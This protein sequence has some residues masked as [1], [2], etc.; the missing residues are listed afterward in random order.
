MASLQEN[1][2]IMAE[3]HPAVNTMKHMRRQSQDLNGSHAAG[4]D[5]S[6]RNDVVLFP[7]TLGAA[8]EALMGP[9]QVLRVAFSQGIC[10][11]WA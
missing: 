5:R 2:Q 10:N 9:T 11:N 6:H 3:K 7:G 1:H 8:A 4:K